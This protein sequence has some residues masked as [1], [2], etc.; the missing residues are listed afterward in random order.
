VNRKK[1]FILA[2]T[3]TFLILLYYLGIL[4]F[5]E[6]CDFKPKALAKNP[7]KE[8][9]CICLGK[10][11]NISGSYSEKNY[12]TGFNLSYNRL[13]GIFS[14]GQHPLYRRTRP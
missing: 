11:H 10:V 8:W 3:A 5:R 6:L 13:M 4:S 12:C 1:I 2:L 7:G 14:K 9:P